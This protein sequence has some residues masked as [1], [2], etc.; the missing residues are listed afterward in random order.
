M[1]VS[2]HVVPCHRRCHAVN[3]PTASQLRRK[4]SRRSAA[5]KSRSSSG[6]QADH[7]TRTPTRLEQVQHTLRGSVRDSNINVKGAV[8]HRL[9]LQAHPVLSCHGRVFYL[10]GTPAGAAAT[11]AAS[12][13]ACASKHYVFLKHIHIQLMQRCG[14]P[15]PLQPQQPRLPAQPHR[16]LPQQQ[17]SPGS[18]WR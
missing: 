17:R 7:R 16:R 9:H 18:Q 13:A 6:W 10:S 4:A 3:L 2:T 11:C 8:K 15:R 5:V 14:R 12:G 1:Y